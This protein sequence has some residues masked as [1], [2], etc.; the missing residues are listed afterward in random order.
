MAS[1]GSVSSKII[2][3]ITN[4]KPVQKCCNFFKKD[5][6][7]A[8]A[9]ST[10]ASVVGKDG[11]GCYMYVN[12][13]LNNEKIPEDKR[14][15]VAALDLTNGILMIVAQLGLFFGMRKLNE[16]LFN[17]I[18][19]KSFDKGGQVFKSIATK[20]RKTQRDAGETVSRKLTLRKEY[21]KIRK[22]CLDTFKFITELAAATILA[23]RV[24]VPFI[25]TP[26]AQ[27]VK[28]KMDN[29][30]STQKEETSAKTEKDD[31]DDNDD[32]HEELKTDVNLTKHEVY[33]NSNLL[34]KYVKHGI[35]PQNQGY[36]Q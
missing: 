36:K 1:V 3:G 20:I 24:I 2:G 19:E 31:D 9:Y 25:A 33:H 21:D 17:K 13:S 7:K 10:I 6:E 8:I 4:F 14:K 15:F 18:F 32:E 28:N 30:L 35:M 27:K 5:P 23:K 34:A 11:I 29:K 22:D 12:Q 26:L 16:P